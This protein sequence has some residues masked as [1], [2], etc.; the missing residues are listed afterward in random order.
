MRGR[1]SHHLQESSGSASYGSLDTSEAS[2]PHQGLR[3]PL[4]LLWGEELWEV[5]NWG[6][7]IL[8]CKHT[9]LISAS[10]LWAGHSKHGYPPPIHL[11]QDKLLLWVGGR[12][13]APGDKT[14]IFFFLRFYLFIHEKHAERGR[15]VGRKRGRFTSGSLMQDL[16][17]GPWIMTWA[18]G[19]CSTTEPP[20]CP[21]LSLFF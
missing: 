5:R 20:R 18:E 9:G 15:D 2:D 17:P 21:V 4:P 13:K 7:S 1:G 16:I 3:V 8:P 12:P 19:R 6:L 11:G 14:S 10:G